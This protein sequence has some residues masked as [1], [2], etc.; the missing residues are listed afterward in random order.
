MRSTPIF[1]ILS[2]AVL[3]AVVVLLG[4]EGYR[5]FYRPIAVSVAYTGQITDSISVT[6]WVIRQEKP[7]PET[8]GTLLRQVQEGEKV[9]AGQTVAMAYA[10]KGA[11]E[12]VKEL[13]DAEM[14]LQ[15]LQ[16]ARNSY[17]DSDAALKVD[18]DISDSIYK[19]RAATAD[20]DYSTAG[21]CLS[22]VKTA[23]LKRSYSYESLEQ[24]DTEIRGTR[25]DIASLQGQ[26]SG[27]SAI[28]A[29]SGGYYSGS[30]DGCEEL[31]S[32]EFLKDLTPSRLKTV[33]AGTAVKNAGKIITDSTWYYAAD[34]PAESARK[35]TVGQEVTLRLS[36]GLKQ[37]T[38]AYVYFIS[39]EEDGHMAVVLSCTRYI[40]QVTL[41]RRQQA[42]IILREYSGIRIPTAALRMDESGQMGVYCQ[43][44]AYVYLKPVD[45]IYKGSGFCLVESA[46]G[47]SGE[48]VL[49][50]GDLVIS[51]AQQLTD[52]MILPDT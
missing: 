22:A 19:L 8:S 40:S 2:I 24:I 11:L 12:V 45:L 14:K 6:G 47:A 26:L 21:D 16:F 18:S 39:P 49:R 15:Q 30:T 31:L 9:H 34:L 50:Q 46:E 51:T 32:P 44:G 13:E 25:A 23:V 43:I 3:V 20:G 5:Y 42:E 35:L 27:A 10:D 28:R 1:K 36:M 7:L 38:P 29:G 52:G 48:R 4:V 33:S 37:D 41:L 17:L